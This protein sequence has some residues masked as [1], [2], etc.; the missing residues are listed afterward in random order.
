M[1]FFD[2]ET[3]WEKSNRLAREQLNRLKPDESEAKTFGETLKRKYEKE[4]KEE[5]D[6]K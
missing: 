4:G 2:K 5:N 1:G 3:N 6:K